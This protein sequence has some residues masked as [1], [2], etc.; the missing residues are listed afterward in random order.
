MLRAVYKESSNW[1]ILLSTVLTTVS[2]ASYPNGPV[3]AFTP[4][5]QNGVVHEAEAGLAK[6]MRFVLGSMWEGVHWSSDE[7]TE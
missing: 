1:F 4:S 3:L 2:P 7:G 5:Y 6:G